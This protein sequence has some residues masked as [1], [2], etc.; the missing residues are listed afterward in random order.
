MLSF[1]LSS[2]SLS[3]CIFFFFYEYGDHR[4]LHVLTH[5]FPTRRS[6]DLDKPPRN[7]D[8]IADLIKPPA[9]PAEH[10]RHEHAAQRPVTSLAQILAVGEQEEEI[11]RAHV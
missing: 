4:D 2:T 1:L 6:S 8:Q 7:S 9:P 5:S 11:G 10:Q 3:L